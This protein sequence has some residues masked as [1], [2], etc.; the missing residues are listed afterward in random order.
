M[1]TGR[2]MKIIG[3]I[4]LA[5]GLLLTRSS[6]ALLGPPPLTDVQIGAWNF[7]DTNWLTMVGDSPISFT[8]L[9]NPVD[10]DGH[11]LQVDSPHPA[12]L[13]YNIVE[14]D[15][16]TNL[17]FPQGTIELWFNPDWN[18][19][20]GAGDSGR[21]IDVGAYG[22]NSPSSWWSLYFNPGGTNLYFSSETNG[23]FTNYLTVPISWT[24][25]NWHLIDLA[26]SSSQSQLYI[27]GQLV[28]NGA[29]SLYQPSLSAF[30]DGFFVGS[31]VTGTQ[32]MRGQ[33]ADLATFNYAV[34]ADMVA[35]DYEQATNGD[36]GG[37]TDSGGGRAEPDY[38]TNLWLAF[39]SVVSNTIPLVL[40]NT[41]A[42]DL[43]EIQG[44]TNLAQPVWFS[45]GFVNGSELT[46]WTEANIPIRHPGNLFLRI[47]NWQDTTGTGI[48]DW[49]WLEYFGQTTNVDAYTEDP[50]D[51]GLTDLQKYQMGLNPTNY[52][53]PNA[54]AGFVGC[55]DATGT[56]FP[57]MEYNRRP[58][59][60]YHSER[61]FKHEHW[62][63][64]LLTDHCQYQHNLLQGCRGDHQCQLT[65]QH[66]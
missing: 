66:L 38:G 54:L 13:Q 19:G 8:N 59:D 14:E 30:T 36:S 33:M 49:W 48:P 50:A 25:N 60:I 61:H 9:D 27:D 53:A 4:L 23:V 31:D 43:L 34:G 6:F 5:L 2:W 22:T 41:P 63:L 52:Y 44:C 45:L 26:Y 62:Q 35:Y 46:N 32:Q 16:T 39:S 28:T 40:S 64:C 47:R 17:T 57:G 55:T 37:G 1:T 65:E 56:N 24:S 15:N 58:G 18:S 20:H 10:W 11:A 42:D 29:G 7:D 51:D 12:W 21:L 3:V